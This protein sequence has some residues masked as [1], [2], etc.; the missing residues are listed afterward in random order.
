MLD[1]PLGQINCE[2]C[3]DY[4]IARWSRAEAEQYMAENTLLDDNRRQAEVSKYIVWP[5]QV[6]KQGHIMFFLTL[7]II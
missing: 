5:G 2:Y 4:F 3:H 1:G 7:D 6:K